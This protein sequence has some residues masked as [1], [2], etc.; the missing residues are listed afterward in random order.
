MHGRLKDI[1]S[2]RLLPL[3]RTAINSH[4]NRRLYLDRSLDGI[5]VWNWNRTCG[6]SMYCSLTIHKFWIWNFC[7]GLEP[8]N[9]FSWCLLNWYTLS[10]CTWYFWPDPGVWSHSKRFLKQEQIT[11]IR[12]IR[13]ACMIHILGKSRFLQNLNHDISYDCKCKTF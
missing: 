3:V 1:S 5:M 11:R 9:P 12:P 10:L 6:W 2:V 7:M 13:L 4:V 8:S